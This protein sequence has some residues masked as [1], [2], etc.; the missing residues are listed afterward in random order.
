M[1]GVAW[2]DTNDSDVRQLW[3]GGVPRSQAGCRT[4]SKAGQR[5]QPQGRSRPVRMGSSSPGPRDRTTAATR[6]FAATRSKACATGAPPRCYPKLTPRGHRLLAGR[7]HLLVRIRMIN[8]GRIRC[9]RIGANARGQLPHLPVRLALRR[10]QALSPRTRCGR[11]PQPPVPYLARAPTR[12]TA[13]TRTRRSGGCRS[14]RITRRY[15]FLHPAAPPRPSRCPHPGPPARRRD[16]RCLVEIQGE[17][18]G[19]PHDVLGRAQHR[20][21]ALRQ[22][23]EILRVQRR[24][25]RSAQLLCNSAESH[26]FLP[27]APTC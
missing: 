17:H 16:V 7:V 20:S 19:F 26:W 13:P 22:D 14:S 9:T 2:T 10:G 11:Q 4:E 8:L 23:T 21:Q 6:R 27:E 1:A 25:E 5:D 12:F 3:R 15:G 18:L 24:G